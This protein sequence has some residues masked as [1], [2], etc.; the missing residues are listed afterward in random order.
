[1]VATCQR[2][3]RCVH[4]QCYAGSQDGVIDTWAT[5]NEVDVVLCGSFYLSASSHLLPACVA[6]TFECLDIALHDD[7]WIRECGY[8]VIHAFLPQRVQARVGE[9]LV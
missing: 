3:L 4:S 8:R 5:F 6:E 7:V 9:R 2:I 1:M